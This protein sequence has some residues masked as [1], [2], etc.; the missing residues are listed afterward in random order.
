MGLRAC[1]D[2]GKM[3]S[4]QADKCPSCGWEDLYGWG[5]LF[6]VIVILPLLFLV[7]VLCGMPHPF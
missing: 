6:A 7:W 3:I 2:C 1:P 4:D 5:C